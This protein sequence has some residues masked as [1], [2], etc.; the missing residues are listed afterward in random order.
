MITWSHDQSVKRLNRWWPFTINLH[1]VKFGSHRSRG[2]GDIPFFIS[3]VTS[4]GHVVIGWS[5]PSVVAINLVEVEIWSILIFNVRRRIHMMILLQS[6][7]IQFCRLFWHISYYKVRQS[8]F[9]TKCDRL[10]LQ[11]A[12]GITKCDRL[13]L[14]IASG[15]TKC[16]R[17]Y[18]KVRQV[19]QSATVITKW[20]VTEFGVPRSK[21]YP[22]TNRSTLFLLFPQ[23]KHS[24][25][26]KIKVYMYFTIMYI[27]THRLCCDL[28]M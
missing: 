8:N 17:L 15:I 25:H 14:Q 1:L 4:C 26:T 9:I 23:Q 13:L 7:I 11:S 16:D 5:L 20:D 2:G 6:V 27:F 21:L 24:Y 10:L 19:L 3:H 18:Y 12:S 28:L 22:L